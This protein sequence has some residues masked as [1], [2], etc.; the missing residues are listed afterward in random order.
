MADDYAGGYFNAVVKDAISQL[1]KNGSTVVF[2]QDQVDAI[3]KVF[4][5][6][7]VKEDDGFYYIRRN[8]AK[9]E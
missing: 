3:R 2:N 8:Y 1:K 5:D 7:K 6:I 4:P 9:E